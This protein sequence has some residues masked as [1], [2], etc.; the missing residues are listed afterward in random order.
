MFERVCGFEPV[1]LHRECLLLNMKDFKNYEVHACVLGDR[2][3]W[4][5]LGILNGSTGSTHIAVT[6]N[7]GPKYPMYPL[8][9]FKF[10]AIDF[11]KI[12][13]E[14]YE[15]FVVQGG[16]QTI[17]AH[18]PI[19][20]LEQKPGKV[21]WYGRKRYDARDLLVSWGARQQFEI[22]GDCCLTWQ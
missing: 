13:V 7:D 20:I 8:D 17:K 22:K 12:D 14:G 11:I 4:T 16:E 9:Y 3:D 1:A 5:G 19:I 10:E 18:K 6:E 15:Y 21:E 2:H